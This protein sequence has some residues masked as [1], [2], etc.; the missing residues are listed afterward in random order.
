VDEII[1]LNCTHSSDPVKDFEDMVST[2]QLD[3]LSTPLSYGGGITDLKSVIK[4]ISAGA[5]RVVLGARNFKNTDL[6]MDIRRTVGDQ[7]VII[8]FCIDVDNAKNLTDETRKFKKFLNILPK[9]WGGEILLTDSLM[10]GAQVPRLKLLS[11]FA[12]LAHPIGIVVSGGFSLDLD[13]ADAIVH[14]NISG[15]AIGN[16]L[17]RRENPISKLKTMREL[18]IRQFEFE[19][20]R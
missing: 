18:Q 11:Q 16:H 3:S 4:I 7:A 17:H 5:E 6:L 14:P 15:V 10:D 13:I 19:D 20:L 8:H 2:A 9:R 12:I 1:I